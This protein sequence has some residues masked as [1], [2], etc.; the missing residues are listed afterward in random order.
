MRYRIL[1]FLVPFHLLG[2]SLI[3]SSTAAG[4]EG[5]EFFEQKIRPVLVERCYQCHSATSQKLKGGLHLDSRQG[6]LKGGD[7]RPAVV[8]GQA[9][10]SLLIEAIRYENPDLQMPPKKKLPDDVVSDFVSW[11]KQGAPWPEEI[12][13]TN[14]AKV[15][16][17]NLEQRRQQHW[18]WHPIHPEA[19]PTVQNTNWPACPVDQFILA[20]LEQAQ[21]K[22]A[23]A[24]DKRTL[25]RR[26]FFDLVGLP[27]APREVEAFLNDSSPSAFEK[28]V[29][30]LL[31]LP[32]FGE[33]WAR[34]W[35]DLVRYADTLGHEFDYPIIN[36]WRYRDYVIRAF[37]SD[38][39]YDQFVTEQIAG[40]LLPK[41][42]RNPAAGFNESIIG[43]AFFWL[44]QRSHSPVDVRQ[45]VAEI[46]DN[47][48]DVMAKTFLGLT[49][50]CARC[51]D[52]KF[53]AISTRDYYSLF[54]VLGSSRYAQLAIDA[55]QPFAGHVEALKALKQKI[56]ALVGAV[57]LEQASK[58]AVYLAAAGE[59]LAQGPS[60]ARNNQV[61]VVSSTRHLDSARLAHWVEALDSNEI[62]QPNHPLFAW[63]KLLAPDSQNSDTSFAK[64]V[65]LVLAELT[66]PTP[67]ALDGRGQESFADFSAADFDGWSL[68]DEAFGTGPSSAGDFVIGDPSHPVLALLTEP[69]ANSA[70]I[71]RRLEGVL[72]SP[73]FT[74]KNRY[75][76]ILASGS[77][78]RL[79]VRV[80]NFTMI[81]E[82][83]YGGL[84]Q[85]LDKEPLH[86]LTVDL[87]TWNGHRAYFEFEDLT[88]PDPSDEASKE[89]SNLAYLAVSRVVL[90][91]SSSPPLTPV[92]SLLLY[93]N[94]LVG[95]T[96]P[97]QLAELYQRATIAAVKTWT[98]GN[99]ATA[100]QIAWLE[101]LNRKSLLESDPHDTAG[102][103]LAA[104]VSEMRKTEDSVPEHA[105]TIGM[106]DGTGLDENVFIRGNHKTPGEIVPRR[107]LQALGGSEKT[108]FANGSGRL[109]LAH[110]LVD[111]SDPFLA[112]V[113]VNRVWLHLFG[114]GIVP[115]PDDFGALG[116][117][118]THPEL[119]DWLADWCRTEGGWSTKKLI[120]LLVNSQTYRMSSTASDAA[121]EEKDPQNLLFHRMPIRRLE[122]EPIRDAI[123]SISGQLDPQMFGPP[124]PI[125]LTEFMEGRGRPAHS[126]PLD[127]SGRRSIYQALHRNFLPPMMRAFDFPVPF[128]TIGRRTVSNVPAQSLILMNDP[129]VIGQAKAWAK[130]LLSKPGLSAEQRIELMYESSFGRPPVSSELQRALAFLDQQGKAYGPEPGRESSEEAVWS[131]FCQVLMNVKEFIFLN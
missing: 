101:W 85:A 62:A 60:P 55:P 109:E 107:F 34:H 73:T 88:T 84:K 121:A 24:A 8:P 108:R 51:H 74:I 30:H 49:V 113:M 118:P 70:C 87:D 35:L 105:R 33:R 12:A 83:I 93:S 91:D 68:Q 22:P 98:G 52:H 90:S 81:R 111:P 54:G 100:A 71:S 2:L 46:I 39:P 128:T 47:Q 44:G 110:C 50:A 106:V 69:A 130:S 53:D 28:V 61:L 6:A 37:N 64:K 123:L 59:V 20:R 57:W 5:V 79:N 45:E 67:S 56:R 112:R 125:Y 58:V 7:T 43:T 13:Q 96:S 9:E 95:A 80:D 126:G 120:R 25:I 119:L 27:P 32:Q 66:R 76:H 104:E 11:V 17:F 97:Q 41:P 15:A 10:K 19:A 65:E 86:W 63:S 36:A 122:S 99:R 4:F 116:Q 75:A 92:A 89:F 1:F 29:D 14:A 48:I 103:R 18:S 23:P 3:E 77:G 72:C 124:V 38:L 117:A 127:G 129:F 82:P 26:V 31:S 78:C 114:R 40:D 42:R 94:D 115:T 21:L 16:V 131:D 102:R